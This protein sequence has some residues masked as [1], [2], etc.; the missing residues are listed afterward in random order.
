MDYGI[1]VSQPGKDV[2]VTADRFFT[3][4]SSFQSLKVLEVHQVTTTI[5]VAGTNTIT[6]TH[7]LGYYAPAFVVYNG[8]TTLGQSRSYLMSDSFSDLDIQIALNTIKINVD[9]T[10]DNGNSNTGDTVYFTVYSFV[11]T[12]DTFEAP[13]LST[14]V[15]DNADGSDY[16]FR[17]S[18]PGFDVKTCA[19]V[20]CVATSRRPSMTIHM[21]GIADAGETVAH[22]LGYAPTFFSFLKFDGDDFLSLNNYSYSM[23]E[24]N[25]YF[26]ELNPDDTYY[27]IIFKDINVTV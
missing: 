27:Y 9:D 7:N 8:S 4:S 11:D 5:P 16:G 23:D 14:N 25:I 3:L 10:F 12:F 21:K 15:T 20:D 13:V 18:K 19:D 26:E 17:V 2:K 24:N 1:A 6:I 22:D